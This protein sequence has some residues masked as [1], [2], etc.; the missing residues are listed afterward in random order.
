MSGVPEMVRVGAQAGVGVAVMGC[1]LRVLGF[2]IF[3]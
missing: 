2:M 1:V 3:F